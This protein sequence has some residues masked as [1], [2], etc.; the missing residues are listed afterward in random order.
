MS[1]LQTLLGHKIAVEVFCFLNLVYEV[2][3]ADF[4]NHVVACIED[5]RHTID[6]HLDCVIGIFE[7]LDLVDVAVLSV[8]FGIRRL[9]CANR[10]E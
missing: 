5:H 1:Y 6:D 8:S 2:A 9:L 10:H 4:A 7:C 3:T